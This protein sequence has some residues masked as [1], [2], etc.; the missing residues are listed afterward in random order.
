LG[1][2]EK[3]VARAAQ[4]L[5]PRVTQ[6]FDDILKQTAFHHS[7]FDI[8]HSSIHQ[9]PRF[10]FLRYAPFAVTPPSALSF[11]EI[12]SLQSAIKNPATRNPQLA[13]RNAPP[14]SVPLFVL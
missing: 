11:L 7:T 2:W 10:C 14:A 8:R 13:T 9:A 1:S 12:R 3:E 6:P 5:A 4:V